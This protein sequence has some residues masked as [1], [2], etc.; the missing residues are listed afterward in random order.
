MLSVIQR[1]LKKKQL[2]KIASIIIKQLTCP[3]WL[4]CVMKQLLHDNKVDHVLC[5]NHSPAAIIHVFDL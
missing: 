1:K 5:F 2:S 3:S 4:G